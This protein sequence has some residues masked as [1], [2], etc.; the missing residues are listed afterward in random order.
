MT[1]Q[2]DDINAD[3]SVM[4]SIIAVVRE[5]VNKLQLQEAPTHAPESTKCPEFITQG[6]PTR[7]Q[8]IRDIVYAFKHYQYPI[9]HGQWDAFTKWVADNT[10]YSYDKE[11]LGVNIFTYLCDKIGGLDNELLRQL[12]G[13]V[14][15]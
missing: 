9:K 10:K 6:G 5:K 3:L 2:I 8:M 11:V 7:D 12:H 13:Y 14:R 1:N 4:V 15:T